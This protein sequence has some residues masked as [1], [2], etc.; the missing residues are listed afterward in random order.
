MSGNQQG[1]A[2]DHIGYLMSISYMIDGLLFP[3]AGWLMDEIGRNSAGTVTLAVF[4]AAFL[5]LSLGTHLSLI[6]FAVMAG[7]ANGVSSGLVMTMGADLAP[8]HARG[9]F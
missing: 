7:V 4:T 2:E 1:M 3:V 8:A 6:V 9:P 5:C